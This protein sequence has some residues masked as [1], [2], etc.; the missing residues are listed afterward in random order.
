MWFQQ[1]RE[2]L[3]SAAKDGF[4]T[5]YPLFHLYVLARIYTKE[6]RDKMAVRELFRMCLERLENRYQL[7][8]ITK[9]PLEIPYKKDQCRASKEKDA[10][11][12]HVYVRSFIEHFWP[13]KLFFV[14][15]K[16]EERVRQVIKKL[17]TERRK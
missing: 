2:E 16:D 15:G 3:R 13:E 9:N 1:E 6:E 7:I 5:D 14:E 11:K 10:R 4:I 8:V 12:R 17:K